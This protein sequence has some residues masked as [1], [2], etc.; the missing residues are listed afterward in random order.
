[1]QHV[2]R[3]A[4][5]FLLNQAEITT[6]TADAAEGFLVGLLVSWHSAQKGIPW[7][8]RNL[9][10]AGSITYSRDS[11]RKLKH[12]G[13]CIMVE[14]PSPT[15]WKW[16]KAEGKEM[17]VPCSDLPPLP[18]SLQSCLLCLTFNLIICRMTPVQYS[19]L[20]SKFHL[21]SLSLLLLIIGK[22]VNPIPN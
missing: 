21:I 17:W 16:K 19:A 4:S 9:F 2:R 13:N 22:Y 20:S 6:R 14:G 8:Q 1:M 3:K 15:L 7:Q 11:G 12:Q 10:T 5:Q 18:L